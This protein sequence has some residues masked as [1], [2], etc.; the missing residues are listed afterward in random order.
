MAQPSWV[1]VFQEHDSPR[2]YNKDDLLK[3]AQFNQI[4]GYPEE[5]NFP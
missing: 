1:I 2:V 3:Y 5:L 4:M